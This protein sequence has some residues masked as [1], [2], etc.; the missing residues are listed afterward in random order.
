MQNNHNKK[1]QRFPNKSFAL[2]ASSL[3]VGL[4]LSAVNATAEE[5]FLE[6][7]V[8][9]ATK[10]KASLQDVPLSISAVSGDRLEAAGVQDFES[11]A[12]SVPS[13]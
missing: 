1:F 10:R 11:V 8:V 3:A 5:A 12:A 7:V 4:S 13:L 9:T 6:E 2:A